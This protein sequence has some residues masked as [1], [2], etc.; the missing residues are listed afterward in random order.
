MSDYRPT[1]ARMQLGDVLARLA[2]I[3]S[4]LWL[5]AAVLA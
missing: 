5:I 4:A 1:L 2:L 3:A